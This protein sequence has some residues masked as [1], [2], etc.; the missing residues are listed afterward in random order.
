MNNNQLVTFNVR[1]LN[2]EEK[3]CSLIEDMENYSVDICCLRETKIN[4]E[5][6]KT[7]G[8]YR[9]IIPKNSSQ[10]WK[11][12]HLFSSFQ[13]SNPKVLETK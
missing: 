10:Y 7:Q 13:R 8:G 4:G 5:R 9:I 2:R 12:F 3:R 11:W 1:G 6:D